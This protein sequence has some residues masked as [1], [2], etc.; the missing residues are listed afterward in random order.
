MLPL[1]SPMTTLC[2]GTVMDSSTSIGTLVKWLSTLS[3]LTKPLAFDSMTGC[4]SNPPISCFCH[5]MKVAL[6]DTLP[7]FLKTLVQVFLVITVAAKNW[8]LIANLMSMI[9]SSPVFG[10]HGGMSK[11]WA[12]VRLLE[13]RIYILKR[14]FKI[15]LKK[16]LKLTGLRVSLW[17]ASLLFPS[18]KGHPIIYHNMLR[19]HMNNKLV[20][21]NMVFP[22]VTVSVNSILLSKYVLIPK[23]SSRGKS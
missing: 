2:V 10:T 16:I 3:Y 5:T 8:L 22:H 7:R 12:S 1:K 20:D 17:T 14:G 19:P 23:E 13:W 21:I 6:V 4:R 18:F 15:A 9:V 11:V